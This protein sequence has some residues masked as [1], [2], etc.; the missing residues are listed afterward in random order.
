MKRILFIIILVGI[1]SKSFS[2]IESNTKFKAIPP[3]NTSVKP[4]KEIPKIPE[5]P[6]IPVPNVFANINILNT[7]PKPNNSFQ[8]GKTNPFSMIQKN[9][10]VNPG[11]LIA[12]KLNKK[13]DNEDQIVYRRN[14]NLGD[15]K[16]NSVT[17]KVKYRDY[18]E[19]DG[20]AISVLLND[21]VIVSEIFMASEFQEFEITLEKGFNKIDFLALNQGR[22]GPNTAEFEVF[23]DKGV[24]IS[25]SQWNLAT[26]FRATIILVK[27]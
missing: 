25:A 4:K 19:V 27:E 24:L 7:K 8:M 9:D 1:T 23:D 18:G 11:D 12:R 21:K 5:K 13:P 6:S 20:D 26:G 15:F 3:L 14:Q 17:A 22:V 16:T 10:F 2:Q